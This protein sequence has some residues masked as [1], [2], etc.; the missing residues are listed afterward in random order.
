M[1]EELKLCHVFPI[2][3]EKLKSG[4]EVTIN[5]GGVS[6]LPVIRPLKDSVILEKAPEKLKKYDTALYVRETGQFVLHRVV[7]EK[8]G[9]YIMCGDNQYIREYGVEPQAIKAVMTAIIRDDKKISVSDGKYKMYSVIRVHTQY[10]KYILRKI[11]RLPGTFKRK[12][13]EG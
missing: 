2:I 7:G 5:P 12:Y 3:E 9:K 10:L 11:K 6:M 13:L 4:A 8:N 1:S